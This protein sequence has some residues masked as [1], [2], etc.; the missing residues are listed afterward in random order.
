MSYRLGVNPKWFRKVNGLPVI[1][2]P[3]SP[4][5]GSWK[6]G[7]PEGIIFHYTAGC[8][9]DLSGVF[10]SR[11]VSSQF[12]VDREGRIY[13]YTPVDAVAWHADNANDH[14]IGIEHTALKGQCD[15]TDVQL[16]ASVKL[17][18]AILEYIKDRWNFK[19]PLKKID[20]P[21]LVPGFHDHA[22]GDGVLWNYN[23][24]VDALYR[25]SWDKYLGEIRKELFVPRFV[26]VRPNGE[27]TQALKL[28][29]ALERVRE[30]F[31]KADEGAEVRLKKVLVWE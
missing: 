15:L 26:V 12:S 19:V 28:G 14:Y 10:E 24:H 3:V 6:D 16:A 4:Y 7:H 5:G 17:V 23:R 13:Q 2:R 1:K 8:G 27:K 11:R 30:M 18:A 31:A 25:W 29:E 20:G 9:S 22:D 21:A